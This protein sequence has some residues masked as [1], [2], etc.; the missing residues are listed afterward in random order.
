M[1]KIFWIVL[2][3]VAGAL[4]PIQ[5]GL[6]GRM[7]QA[8]Q[9]PLWAVLI[10]FLVGLVAMLVYV[11]L[12]NDSLKVQQIGQIPS[13][14][15]VAGVLGAIYV[16]T[17]VL[18]FPKLGPALTFGL[19]VAGQLSISVLLEHFN[20]LVQAPHSINWYRV[21]GIVLIV[22]GVVIIRRF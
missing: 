4:L 13:H 16:S 1:E 18:A 9:S 10:S 14:T 3:F 2:V 22:A 8:L 20:I 6:N 7:G 5:A 11:L 17:V 21:A 19:I 15:W 12:M